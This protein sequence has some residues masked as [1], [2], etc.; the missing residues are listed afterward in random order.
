MNLDDKRWKSDVTSNDKI[1]ER[2]YFHDMMTM[3]KHVIPK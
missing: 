1:M 2:A 3:F